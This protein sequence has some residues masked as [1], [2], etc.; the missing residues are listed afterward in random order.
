MSEFE[1]KRKRYQVTALAGTA[2]LKGNKQEAVAGLRKSAT[3]HMS[4]IRN[5]RDCVLYGPP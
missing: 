5:Q 4:M 3:S 2:Q 1:A